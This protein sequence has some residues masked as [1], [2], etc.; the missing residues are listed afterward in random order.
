M[1]RIKYFQNVSGHIIFK[2][3]DLV[4]KMNEILARYYPSAL[5]SRS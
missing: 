2:R 3:P 5:P 1:F 4:D